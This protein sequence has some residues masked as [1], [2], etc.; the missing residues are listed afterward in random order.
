MK[1]VYCIVNE[2]GILSSIKISNFTSNNTGCPVISH[3]ILVSETSLLASS[4][5][6][7]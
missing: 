3:K 6:N 5:V 4:Y 1:S 2:P 7:I